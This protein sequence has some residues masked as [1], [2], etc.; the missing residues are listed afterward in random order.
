MHAVFK[1]GE[2]DIRGWSLLFQQEDAGILETDDPATAFQLECQAIGP[3]CGRKDRAG[4]GR[5]GRSDASTP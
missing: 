4:K 5:Q 3:T 2:E 1:V